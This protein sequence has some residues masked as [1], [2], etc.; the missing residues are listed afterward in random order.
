NFGFDY[1]IYE[2]LVKYSRDPNYLNTIPNGATIGSKLSQVQSTL[3]TGT[4]VWKYI[5]PLEETH[6]IA[7]STAVGLPLK[8]LTMICINRF[9]IALVGFTEGDE[10]E[11]GQKIKGYIDIEK[12]SLNREY[13]YMHFDSIDD[14]N[15]YITAEDYG[16]EGKP[17][18]CFGIYFK[19]NG[20]NDYS[21]SLHYFND[22]IQ[23]GNEDVPNNLRP[24]NEEMQQG[25]N[26]NDVKKYSDN[27]YIP[28]LNII[29]NYI[30]KKSKSIDD[31][32][33]ENGENAYINYGFAIQKYDQYKF[34]DFAG[35]AGVYYTFFAILSYL[36]PL[37]LYVLK[38]VVEKE[39]RSKEVMKIMGMGEGTYF[40]S[41][42]VE[43]FIVN[44]IY[45][46]ALGYISKLT[47]HYIPYLLFVLYLWLFGLNIFALAFFCQSFMDTTK[48][49]LIVS[50]LVYCLMLFVSAAVYDDTIKKTYK[51]I[52]ALLPPVNLLLG[53]F[54][55]G[56]FERMYFDFKT[57]DITEN[58]LNY[59]ISTCYIMFTAD[60]F[61]YLFLGYYLQNVI[62]HEYGV[63][64]PWYFLFLPSYW[65]GDCCK[66]K[67]K[68]GDLVYEKTEKKAEQVDV[69]P[70]KEEQEDD[71]GV[72]TEKIVIE[73][74][75]SDKASSNNSIFDDNPHKGDI[76][77][78]NEDIYRDKNKK[79]DVFMLREVTKVYGDGKMACNKISFNLFRN[80]IFALLGRNG[81]GKTSLINVLIGMYDATSGHAIYKENDVLEERNM[82]E[83]RHKLGICPQHDILFPKLTVREHLE[84]FCY[85]KGFDVNKI[86]DEV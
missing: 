38:M 18:I 80:E 81:A 12:T 39:S 45:A 44:I 75:N 76:D 7:L 23:H 43:Y 17:T 34:N 28:L 82:N 51:I 67:K 85:F 55:F 72:A 53:A 10:L 13:Y 62:P 54:T 42:F 2:H 69:D 8:P 71:N 24:V 47:F 59:S 65:F 64:K 22:P 15:N 3:S 83:F 41:Y 86:K 32:S 40:L 16:K 46:F 21:A 56:E 60:F 30:L 58:Y 37:I 52:A 29:A 79:K 66:K 9:T 26:M 48:L 27:G 35:Y 20:D 4:G 5:D 73:D 84:M 1:S 11:L 31:P 14:L 25:P 68:N 49:A 63:A 33:V 6:N 61:I 57:K 19:K 77:F 78:Q 70:N 50:C 74:V 36:C